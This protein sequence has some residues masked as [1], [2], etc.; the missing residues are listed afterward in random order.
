MREAETGKIAV[1]GQPGQKQLR[2]IQWKK[3]AVVVCACHLSYG[4]YKIGGSS[5][6]LPG[7]KVRPYLIR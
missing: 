5:P 3:L 1:P 2:P 7:Q 4:K 6:E